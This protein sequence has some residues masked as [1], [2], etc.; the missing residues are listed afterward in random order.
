MN[1]VRLD[2]AIVHNFVLTVPAAHKETAKRYIERVLEKGTMPF[3]GLEFANALIDILND[4]LKSDSRTV[5]FNIH[6]RGV[7]VQ[8]YAKLIY[9]HFCNHNGTDQDFFSDEFMKAIIVSKPDILTSN[10]DIV[11]TP[12]RAIWPPK[13]QLPDCQDVGE[14]PYI[15]QKPFAPVEPLIRQL[16]MHTVKSQKNYFSYARQSTIASQIE[17]LCSQYRAIIKETEYDQVAVSQPRLLEYLSDV[18]LNAVQAQAQ[19]KDTT[20]LPVNELDFAPIHPLS[21]LEAS[22]VEAAESEDPDAFALTLSEALKSVSM[23]PPAETPTAAVQPA[24]T[25]KLNLL[26][27]IKEIN[28]EGSELAEMNPAR[29]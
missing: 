25:S 20:A 1:K 15:A 12:F 19:E 7:E 23:F 8:T 13:F 3:T 26:R 16:L 4:F 27:R 22:N 5:F 21:Q 29:K 18:R 17:E 9:A 28:A 10:D 24:R 14:L 6:Q 2:D 11:I